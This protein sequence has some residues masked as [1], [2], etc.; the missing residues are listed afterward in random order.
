MVSR[1]TPSWNSVASP[2]LTV[3]RAGLPQR[4]GV[5][6]WPGGA[7]TAGFHCVASTRLRAGGGQ[8][9]QRCRDG[10]GHGISGA[11]VALLRPCDVHRR[12]TRRRRPAFR[13]KNS[14]AVEAWLRWTL[15]QPTARGSGVPTP[16]GSRTETTAARR[17]ED[18][19][20][21]NKDAAQRPAAKEGGRREEENRSGFQPGMPAG[22]ATQNC[23]R[24]PEGHPEV[25]TRISTQSRS[26][27]SCDAPIGRV[28][29]KGMT[30]AGTSP[31]GKAMSHPPTKMSAAPKDPHALP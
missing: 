14:T 26:P 29:C 30:T 22:C 9:R 2:R 16:W 24:V 28:F 20:P 3:Q 15:G 21:R 11:H 13:N 27:S 1:A 6:P 17:R 4:V 19:G 23:D 12:S 10:E 8:R 31:A 5:A 18:G 7:S 25:V